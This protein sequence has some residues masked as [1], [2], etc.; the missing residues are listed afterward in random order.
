MAEEDEWN[1]LPN[2]VYTTAEL[3]PN[4]YI[5][6]DDPLP[7]PKHY[8]VLAPFKPSEPGVNIR[9]IRKPK[10]KPIEI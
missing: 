2:G 8:G 3:R 10:S 4:A 6:T 9:H 7:V 5:P 1:Q